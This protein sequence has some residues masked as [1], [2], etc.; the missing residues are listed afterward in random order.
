MRSHVKRYE[1]PI[2]ACFL[3]FTALAVF[4]QTPSPET[5]LTAN[6]VF[7]K[8]CAKC[9]GIT[10]EGHRFAG[11]SLVSPKIASISTEELRDTIANGKGH[12]PKFRMPAFSDKLTSEEIDTLARQ[13]QALSKKQ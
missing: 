12:V 1:F 11:P 4:G 8:S 6:P 5:N 10:A 13:I 3:F 7:Q 9:H 2:A